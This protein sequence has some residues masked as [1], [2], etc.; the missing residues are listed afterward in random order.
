MASV[1]PLD[2]MGNLSFTRKG[3]VQA[4][5]YEQVMPRHLANPLGDNEGA[6]RAKWRKN[7]EY[8]HVVGARLIYT[9]SWYLSSPVSGLP[10]LVDLRAGD[11]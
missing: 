3:S 8:R 6:G 11:Y 7:R 4:N 1:L 5:V 2:I 9:G 10:T